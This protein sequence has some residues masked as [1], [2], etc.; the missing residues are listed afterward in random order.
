MRGNINAIKDPKTTDVPNRII[1][2]P[3]YIGWR[4]MAK[5]PETS[6]FVG[7]SNG[8]MVV[9]FFLNKASDQIFNTTPKTII[10][11]PE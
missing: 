1:V 2:I 3:K 6:S 5:G 7:S 4:L 9:F 8:F 11:I 10:A